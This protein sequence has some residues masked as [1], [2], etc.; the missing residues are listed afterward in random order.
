[1]AIDEYFERNGIAPKP[2]SDQTEEDK[3]IAKIKDDD[4]YYTEYFKR[5]LDVLIECVDFSLNRQL[6]DVVLEEAKKYEDIFEPYC[7]SGIFGCYVASETSG[8]YRG[9]DINPVGIEKAKERAKLNGLAPEIFTLGDLFE[10]TQ[11]HEAV[12]GRYVSNTQG[13]GVDPKV[14]EALSQISD[15][16]VLIQNLQPHRGMSSMDMY[17]IAFG[18]HGYDNFEL[19]SEPQRSTATGASVFVMKATK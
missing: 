3:E 7:Q 9:L 1:M 17:K 14:V 11:S 12:V 8:A 2:L 5:G 18:L 19:L 4:I 10:Y 15:N 13:L 6:F 16:V